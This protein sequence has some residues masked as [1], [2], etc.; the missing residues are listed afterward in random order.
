MNRRKKQKRPELHC[1]AECGKM[2]EKQSNHARGQRQREGEE[3]RKDEDK[4]QR[5]R[6]RGVRE[7]WSDRKQL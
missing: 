3:K 5:G 7:N 6:E 2:S 1:Q 4:E